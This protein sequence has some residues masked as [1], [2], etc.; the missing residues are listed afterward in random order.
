MNRALSENR[1]DAC[2]EMAEMFL[3]RYM[4]AIF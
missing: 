4:K 3:H 2:A 1:D